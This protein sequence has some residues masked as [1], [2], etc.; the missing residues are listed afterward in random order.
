MRT[1]ERQRGATLLILLTVVA[2]GA[3]SLFIGAHAQDDRRQQQERR[4]VA[5]INEAR[6]ALIGYAVAHGRLPRPAT[7]ALDGA[8]NPQA[9]AS[10]QAC[11]GF[12]PWTTLALARADSWGK[13]LRYSVTPEYTNAPVQRV[14]AVGTKT[15]LTRDS[16]GAITYLAGNPSCTP[17]S[18][19]LVAVVYSA[20]RENFGTSALGIAQPNG[21]ATNV[22]E[23]AND[24]ALRNFMS[25]ASSDDVRAPG[26]EFDDLVGFI[27]PEQLYQQMAR[28]KALP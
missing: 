14:S 22:D 18:S 3:A 28:A 9:C 11:T 2:L 7:S 17:G 16:T 10:E 5:A 15:V 8:E 20:G 21:S 26:G 13:L 24:R 27:A 19:C 1:T 25:R 6:E 23:A 4:T 12:L